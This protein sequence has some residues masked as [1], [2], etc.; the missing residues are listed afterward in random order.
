VNYFS[1]K[2]H[3]LKKALISSMEWAKET[4]K[5]TLAVLLRLLK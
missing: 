2:V 1:K 3:F 4:S 5:G